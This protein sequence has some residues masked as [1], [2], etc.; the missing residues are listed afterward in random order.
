MGSGVHR[1]STGRD[2]VEEGLRLGEK[3]AGLR[4]KSKVMGVG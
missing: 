3:A 1:R 4:D 2:R